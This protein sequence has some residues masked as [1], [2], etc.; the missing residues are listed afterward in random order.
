MPPSRGL[1]GSLLACL[2]AAALLLTLFWIH[3]YSCLPA[4]LAWNGLAF[5]RHEVTGPAIDRDWVYTDARVPPMQSKLMLTISRGRYDAALLERKIALRLR[6]AGI[7]TGLTREAGTSFVVFQD[8]GRLP[9]VSYYKLVER[10]GYTWYAD[11]SQQLE[12]MP[13]PDEVDVL[14]DRRAEIFEKLATLLAALIGRG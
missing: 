3:F 9:V 10:G 5:I 12:R 4:R 6:R 2:A 11:F 8:P 1:V 13:T 14:S 7:M